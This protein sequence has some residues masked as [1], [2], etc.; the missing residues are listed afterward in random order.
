MSSF[1]KYFHIVP[2]TGWLGLLH[3]LAKMG[4][5]PSLMFAILEAVC[6]DLIVVL[7]I[8]LFWGFEKCHDTATAVS[9]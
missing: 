6:Y 7:Y 9:A 4:R 1:S 2:R 5:C 8:V 3:N